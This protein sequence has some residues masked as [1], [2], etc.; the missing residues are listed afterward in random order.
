MHHVIRMQLKDICIYGML[1]T[2]IRLPEDL[3]EA[4]A[5]IILCVILLILKIT[6]WDLCTDTMCDK[7]YTT[8]I[9]P[10]E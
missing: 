3:Y 4:P 6:V 7:I 1:F 10:E 9:L 2:D 8:G 5:T